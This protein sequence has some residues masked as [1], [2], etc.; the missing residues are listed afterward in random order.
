MEMERVRRV[1]AIWNWLPAFR[2]VAETGNI[3]SASRLLRISASSLS[4]TIRLLENEVG[5]PLF[6]RNGRSIQLNRA[7]EEF[8]VAVRD[9]IRRVDDGLAQIRSNRLSGAIYI[10]RDDSLVDHLLIPAIRR[11][12]EQHP[13]LVPHVDYFSVA[14]SVARVLRGQLDVAISQQPMHAR[15]VTVEV[16]GT[17]PNSVYCAGG[18]PLFGKGVVTESELREHLFAVRVHP[19][20]QTPVDAWSSEGQ[21]VPGLFAADVGMALQACAS[22]RM[23]ALL[24]DTLAG[25]G[26]PPLHR[27]AGPLVAPTVLYA[28]RRKTI[29]EPG[30][31]ELLVE[32][33]QQQVTEALAKRGAAGSTQPSSTSV[34]PSS[35][36]PR[37]LASTEIK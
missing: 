17:I 28:V 27:L 36:K 29:A 16:L 30:R 32:L 35:N 34:P 12:N 7:G 9:S 2:S 21:R 25:V 6:C 24:P 20:T 11:L 1:R 5:Q 13:D 18:H 37:T 31:A 3:N 33:L 14:E 23:L 4:R 26:N 8:L 10:S 19:A 15:E 22:G